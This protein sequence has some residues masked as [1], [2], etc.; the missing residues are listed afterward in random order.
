V[1]A[2]LEP[3]WIDAGKG[4]ALALR[5]GK[6]V[7]R[8]ARGQILASVPKAVRDGEVGER[9]VAMAEW[10]DTHARE[11]VE[12]VESWMLRALPAPRLALEEAWEDPAWRAAL[13]NA[14]VVP[15]GGAAGFFRGV[16]RARGVGAVNLDGETEWTNAPTVLFAHPIALADLDEYR[17][18]A[19]ELSLEQGIRQLFRETFRKPAELHPDATSVA[20]FCGGHFEQ[21]NHALGL[22]RRLGYRVAGGSAV[23]RVLE[24]G[25]VFEARFWIGA[26]DPMA[27]TVTDALVW[28]EGKGRVLPVREVGTVAFSEGMRMA[29]AI[30]AGRAVPKEGDGG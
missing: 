28:V 4:Y 19:V 17:A 6:L 30:Y 18:M 25:K 3:G 11:C 21:L 1:R 14:V 7:C 20:D 12:A 13:E 22:C 23:T 16:D 8:N 29:S 24:G 10:L 9:L 27:E 26:E 2:A 5:D 15:E